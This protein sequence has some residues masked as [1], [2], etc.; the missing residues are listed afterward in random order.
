L[1]FRFYFCLIAIIFSFF[2][3][4][5]AEQSDYLKAS[6][7]QFSDSLVSSGVRVSLITMEP[8]KEIYL[9]FGHSAIRIYDHEKNIDTLF[10]FGVFPA[11][12]DPLFVFTFLKGTMQYSV[13][14]GRFVPTI[15]YDEQQQNRAWHEQELSLST[16]QAS[17]LY[18]Y[19]LY[20]TEPAHS[21]FAYDCVRKNC[22]TQAFD[23]LNGA[24]D[25]SIQ[26]YQK[27]LLN[28]K[29]ILP[30]DSFYYPFKSI[31]NDNLPTY[32][33]VITSKLVDKPVISFGINLLLGTNSDKPLSLQEATF[34]PELLLS[35][36]QDATLKTNGNSERK[37]VL[38]VR[39]V[40]DPRNGNIETPPTKKQLFNYYLLLWVLAFSFMILTTYQIFCFKTYRNQKA[41][42]QTTGP[43]DLLLFL[44]TGIVGLLILFMT[45]FSSHY[46][47]KLN[48]NF[49]W[50]FPPHIMAAFTMIHH[51]QNR[52]RALYW[53]TALA[54]SAIPFLAAP[55]WPQI[56]TPAMTPLML[57]IFCRETYQLVCSMPYPWYR[58]KR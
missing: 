1:K 14:S 50:L 5:A 56:L 25:G 8:G 3:V 15:L 57:I 38:S 9:A 19:L 48:L 44:I 4:T 2:A 47:V 13:G 39:T 43:F 27:S 11:A 51:K 31:R 45:F 23:A 54:L 12:S 36:M 26:L 10:N 7:S 24:T 55:V 37:L 49:L 34:M 22:A 40:Y 28:D 32:R 30:N 42:E 46:A 35:L 20:V 41:L 16:E 58:I 18:S 21:S 6:S 53:M 33:S 29:T 52:A 17:S